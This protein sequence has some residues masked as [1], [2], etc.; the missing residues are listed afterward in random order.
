[1]SNC[2]ECD[3]INY[4]INPRC[5]ACV[6]KVMGERIAELEAQKTRSQEHYIKLLRDK[7]AELEKLREARKDQC[8]AFAQW[9]RQGN[10]RRDRDADAC[11]E[12][13]TALL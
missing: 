13:W 4:G 11:Y 12:L 8:I 6:R 7:E 9:F 5:A 3:V 10:N 1:M 2:P